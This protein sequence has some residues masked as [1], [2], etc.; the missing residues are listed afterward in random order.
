MNQVTKNMISTQQVRTLKGPGSEM[1]RAEN[2]EL[3]LQDV[4]RTTNHEPVHQ[5]HERNCNTFVTE[6]VGMSLTSLAF[7]YATV[8]TTCSLTA[9]Q[10]AKKYQKSQLS[11]IRLLLFRWRTFRIFRNFRTFFYYIVM[12]PIPALKAPWGIRRR[13]WNS[14]RGHGT[15]CDEHRHQ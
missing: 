4:K 14:C 12:L 13:C 8:V 7:G 6:A 1:R 9:S 2:H 15:Q 5:R 11:H 10:H 3:R